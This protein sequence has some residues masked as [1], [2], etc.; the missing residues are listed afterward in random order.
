MRAMS[1]H[2]YLVA[3]VILC[4]VNASLS[5]PA[6]E[7]RAHAILTKHNN[8]L[9]THSVTL[10]KREGESSD[11]LPFCVGIAP[12]PARVLVLKNKMDCDIGGFKTLYIFTAHTKQDDFLAP[13]PMCGGI[14]ANPSRSLLFR[15]LTKCTLDGWLT[16]FA[17]Y[18]SSNVFLATKLWQAPKPD[19]MLLYPYYQGDKHGWTLAS[20]LRYVAHFRLAYITEIETLKSEKSS[21]L[22]VHKGLKIISATNVSVMRCITLMIAFLDQASLP[23]KTLVQRGKEMSRYVKAA[24]EA[25]CT[26]V[27]ASSSI[28]SKRTSKSNYGTI[29]IA[30]NNNIYAAISMKAGF[31]AQI[32][33]LRVAFHESMRTN[34]PVMVARNP[35]QPQDSIVALVQGMAITIGNSS[36]IYNT[37]F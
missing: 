12:T 30:V 36:R 23:A 32:E 31:S 15:N 20:S 6:Y 37:V 3:C 28:R 4:T 9:E 26:S 17:F 35:D 1:F 24:A 25:K 22:K 18:E 2:R 5:A 33:N 7:R 11:I 16:D 10:S 21:H 13:R 27:V 8:T 14:A 29:E 19:R 34:Q